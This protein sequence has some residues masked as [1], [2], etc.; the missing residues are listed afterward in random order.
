MESK[1][2]TKDDGHLKYMLCHDGSAASEEALATLTNGYMKREEDHLVISHA[3]TLSKEEY[4]NYKF[5]REYVK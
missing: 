4:L 1:Q 3:F 5:K 2:H